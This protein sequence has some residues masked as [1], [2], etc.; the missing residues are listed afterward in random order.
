[1]EANPIKL[2]IGSG[3]RKWPGF[4]N[5]DLAGNW[6]DTPPDV[7]ADVTQPLP[8]ADNYADE[9]HAIHLLEHLL[10][11]RAPHVL[12]DWRRILKPGGLLVLEMPCLDKIAALLAHAMIDGRSPDY[13]LTIWGLF[14]NPNY[15]VDAMT[16]R[17]CYS[18][19][20][21]INEL[22]QLEF[23]DV[24]LKDTQFHQKARDMR[25]EARKPLS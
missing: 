24:E 3:A 25:I 7:V 4:I 17:W 16:H 6:A 12:L 11:W 22:E 9:I 8:F 10:R 1:V 23:V 15:K 14:G 5:V 21:I 13:R 20:E 2:N 18:I 19:A